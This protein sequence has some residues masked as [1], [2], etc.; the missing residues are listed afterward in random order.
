MGNM[1][2]R[3][4]TNL[5]EELFGKFNFWETILANIGLESLVVY[6]RAQKLGEGVT[7]RPAHDTEPDDFP[8]S[9]NDYE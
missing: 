6:L 9:A 1:S 5:A 4:K 8:L 3:E 2:N 7:V